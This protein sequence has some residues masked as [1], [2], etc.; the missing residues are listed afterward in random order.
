MKHGLGLGFALRTL[1]RFPF[2]GKPPAREESSLFWYAFIGLILGGASALAAWLIRLPLLAGA[3]FTAILAWSTR[4]FHLDGLG[5]AADGFGGGFTPQRSLE[6]MSDSHIG[7][8]GTVAISL[9][10]IVKTAAASELMS[11]SA[12]PASLALAPALGRTAIVLLCWISKYAKSSGKAK[13]LTDNCRIHHV[14]TAFVTSAIAA[15]GIHQ[16]SSEASAWLL[17]SPFAA[18]IIMAAWLHF[19]SKR[20]T[21]GIT[22]DVAG[23]C[24]ELTETLALVMMA[25]AR[26]LESI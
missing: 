21:G 23:A 22:G 3:A 13:A 11:M 12:S 25:I 20:K 19:V 2:P 10:L 1:T 4:A 9:C 17:A 24:C 5:D 7:S 18:A 15:W 14:L 16:L 8:F 6:I 26:S